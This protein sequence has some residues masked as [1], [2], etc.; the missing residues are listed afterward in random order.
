MRIVL[1]KR[2]PAFLLGEALVTLSLLSGMMVL[3]YEQITHFKQQERRLQQQYQ[4][5]QQARID[6]MKDWHTYVEK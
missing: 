1:C 3:E 6:A 5:A 4:A 2:K